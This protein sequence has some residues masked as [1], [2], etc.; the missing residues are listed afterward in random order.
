MS[1][2]STFYARSVFIY[3]IGSYNKYP[4][5]I[6]ATVADWT[7]KC[8]HILYAMKYELKPF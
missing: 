2:N 8:Q 4:V 7:F 5:F 3:S 1:M 6:R